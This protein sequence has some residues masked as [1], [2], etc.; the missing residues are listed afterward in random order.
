MNEI[1]KMPFKKLNKSFVLQHD[2]SDCG[3]A[4][5]LSIIQF[6]K[7]SS[8]LEKI[9]ELSGTNK[10]GTTLLGLYQSANQLGFTAQGNSADIQALIDHKEPL[11]LH[12]LINNKLQHYV[13]C[14]GFENDK[15]IIGDPSKGI[16][17]LTKDELEKIWVSK[18]CLT[19]TPN[20]K[21]LKNEINIK[22]KRNCFVSLIK[23]D[24]KLLISS[25]VLGIGISSLGMAMAVFSQKLIDD[26]LPSKNINK[27]ITGIILV[28]FLLFVRVIFSALRDYLLIR[29]NRDF[30]N[31]IIN[32]FYSS[33][34]N[35]PKPFFDTRKIG[36]LVARLNDTQRIQKVIN[37][38]VGNT[39]INILVTITSLA[40]L[41][42]YS[43]RTGLIALFSLPIYFFIIY[44]FNNKI[45]K[46]QK[47]VMQ[48][49]AFSES[50]YIST[51][52]GIATIKNKMLIRNFPQANSICKKRLL[53]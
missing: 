8:T 39:V 37:V 6:Y 17:R 29:Q 49:Y 24:R 31:R 42:Y 48:G 19:L 14:Y 7:G 36:E 45:I 22:N 13:V 44:R 5:L 2:Q 33:L 9:R 27:L 12:V 41:F 30:S 15:F 18:N 40:F 23:D 51:M 46:A 4:C 28:A 47:E 53:S 11:I 50:N 35:L 52:Q 1:K 38:I 43:W 20:E 10:Q 16:I 26:I 34:L 32:R 25:I 21:F 3:V